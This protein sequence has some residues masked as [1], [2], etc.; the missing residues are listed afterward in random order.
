LFL[1]FFL[2]PCV[3]LSISQSNPLIAELQAALTARETE[4]AALR[5]LLDQRPPSIAQAG[6]GS[7]TI[8]SEMKVWLSACTCILC[9][10]VSV[11]VCV[12]ACVCVCYYTCVCVCV[13]SA[14]LYGKEVGFV[15]M[16]VCVHML[17]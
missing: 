17:V 6:L 7:N 1:F 4:N 13:C 9:V 11:C 14:L 10:C 8:H 12:S 2:F 5:A 3:F 15:I 16:A